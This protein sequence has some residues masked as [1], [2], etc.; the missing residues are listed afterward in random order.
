MVYKRETSFITLFV[1]FFIDKEKRILFF[2]LNQGSQF[3]REQS[4]L[5]VRKCEF[6]PLISCDHRVLRQAT[7]LVS[8]RDLLLMI[9]EIGCDHDSVLFHTNQFFQMN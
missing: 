5:W 4:T 8:K 7:C 2:I 6:W 3:Y 9:A 1:Q